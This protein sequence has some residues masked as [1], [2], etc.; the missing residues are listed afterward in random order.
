MRNLLL[1]FVL[2]FISTT[3][4]A[5]TQQAYVAP[6]DLRTFLDYNLGADT[7]LPPKVPSMG[8]KGD[9]Y[10]WGRIAKVT[11]STDFNATPPTDNALSDTFKTVNDPCPSG[12]RIPT[13]KEWQGVIDNNS[14]QWVGDFIEDGTNMYNRHTSGILINNSM[15]LPAA[16]VNNYG[17]GNLYSNNVLSDND[18]GK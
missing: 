15:F 16:G 11:S 6:G 17:S 5:Q 3:V 7:S 4:Y 18:L 12:Y 10:Q 1:G 8:L 2:A 9:K 14:I 13:A